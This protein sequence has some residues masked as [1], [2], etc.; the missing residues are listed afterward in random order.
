LTFT[1][2]GGRFVYL[3]I[4]TVSQWL[5]FKRNMDFPVKTRQNR[6]MSQRV[7]RLLAEAKAWCESQG[8]GGQTK[9]AKILGVKRQAVSVWFIQAQE[10]K[11]KK[12]PT[13]EQALHLEEFLKTQ[14]KEK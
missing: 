2:L 3:A 11:P 9:L 5:T 8:E 4:D 6:R 14:R 13:A 1:R 12:N 7:K 10:K